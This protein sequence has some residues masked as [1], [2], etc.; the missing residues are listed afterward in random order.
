M[1]VYSDKMIGREKIEH[2]DNFVLVVLVIG[3]YLY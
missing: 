2:I 3:W 1:V